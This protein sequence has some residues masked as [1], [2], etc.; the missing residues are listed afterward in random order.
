MWVEDK[1]QGMV[2]VRERAEKDLDFCVVYT[3]KSDLKNI[4]YE[5]TINLALIFWFI[6]WIDELKK[7]TR[8]QILQ[9]SVNIKTGTYKHLK[10]FLVLEAEDFS[11]VKYLY[12]AVLHKTAR[13]F[14]TARTSAIRLPYKF[15]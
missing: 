12:P 4:L 11:T 13:Y 15:C 14:Q 9:I 3:F 7:S 8:N 10:E 1:Y 6:P 2:K 5:F